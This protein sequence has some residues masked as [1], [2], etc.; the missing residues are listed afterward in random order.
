VFTDARSS[1]IEQLSSCADTVLLFYHPTKRTQI[2][3]KGIS[4]IKRND[5]VTATMWAKIQG[6]SR[7]A[8]NQ[9][10]APGS[11][12]QNPE[13]AFELDEQMTDS[14]FAVIRISPVEIEALQ[15]DGTE[16]L[17]IQFKLEEK[18]WINKWIAP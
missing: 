4:T 3:V 10:L 5:E 14:N 16:H 15:L 12:L 7:K 6:D 18:G 13:E 11:D 17:R 9:I 8:Y 1:K 2:K